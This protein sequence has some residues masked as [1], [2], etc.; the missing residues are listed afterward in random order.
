MKLIR[1]TTYYS[2]QIY[3]IVVSNP[4]YLYTYHTYHIYLSYIPIIIWVK[5]YLRSS[6]FDPKMKLKKLYPTRSSSYFF[7]LSIN[8]VHILDSEWSGGKLYWYNGFPMMFIFLS[9]FSIFSRNNYN[10]TR[11]LVTLVLNFL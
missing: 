1:Y 9:I 7:V 8:P 10:S 5:T 4:I 2:M 3:Q 6:Q 11:K